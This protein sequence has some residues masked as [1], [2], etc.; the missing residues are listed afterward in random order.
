MNLNE[1]NYYQLLGLQADATE[2]EIKA[3]FQAM[4]AL[5]APGGSQ[6]GGLDYELVR[7]A[8]DVLSDPA[9]RKLYDTL[10]AEMQKP[11]SIEFQLSR[12]N[13]ALID[14]PQMLY[15]LAKLDTPEADSGKVQPLNICLVIDRSTSMR[16]ERLQ[17]VKEALNLL[18]SKLPSGDTL[19][20]VTFSDRA[21]IVLP[22]Q[23]VAE[24]KQLSA[25]MGGIE[26]SGG[27]E[28]YQGLLSGVRQLRKA[29]LKDYNNQLILLTDGRTYGDEAECMRLAEEA[30][31]AGITFHAFGIGS[32]WDESFLDDLVAPSGG[33]VEYI[34]SPSRL[35]AALHQRLQHLGQTHARHVTLQADWPQSVELLDAFRLTPYAQPLQLGGDMIALGD[36]E[37]G[38]ALSFVL[39]FA[40]K[41]QPIPTRIRIPL[42]FSAELP[43][44]GIQTYQERVQLA[45]VADPPEVDTPPDV[46]RAVR[47]LTLYRLHE[48]AREEAESGQTA[49]AAARMRHLSTR[50]LEAGEPDLAHQAELEARQLAQ[51]GSLSPARRKSLR[52]GT[53]A[54]TRKGLQLG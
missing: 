48:R 20:V 35:V 18:M 25:W 2:S 54:L 34:D 5:Y 49:L 28:I 23:P 32:D 51:T 4:S 40:V 13:L 12:Q 8:Y 31:T 15:L 53:R 17:R 37:G 21:E 38:A 29:A 52:Y 33:L 9:R 27:T 22:P 10:L 30:A 47:L 46:F 1:R 50:L 36:I 11:V 43:Q 41:P 44:L 42:H 24:H 7:H 3:A 16:G 14:E 6:E 26:A 19:S 45:V 39:S